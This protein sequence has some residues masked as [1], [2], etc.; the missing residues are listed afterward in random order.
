VKNGQMAGGTAIGTVSSAWATSTPASGATAA[1]NSQLIAP[2]TSHAGAII[3]DASV[4][5]NG[6]PDS[7]GLPMIALLV[8]STDRTSPGMPDSPVGP[9]RDGGVVPDPQSSWTRLGNSDGSAGALAAS[10]ILHIFSG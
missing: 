6:F 3:D 8:P 10:P 2:F 1:A 7:D 5:S 9:T 4:A